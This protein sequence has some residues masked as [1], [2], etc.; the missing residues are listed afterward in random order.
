VWENRTIFY[1]SLAFWLSPHNG[2]GGQFVRPLLP[3]G[4]SLI[5]PTANKAPS[6]PS[7][8][9]QLAATTYRDDLPTL[10]RTVAAQT[11]QQCNLGD[12]LKLHR[13]ICGRIRTHREVRFSPWHANPHAES[14][15]TQLVRVPGREPL[16]TECWSSGTK[17]SRQ[18][19]RIR[20]SVLRTGAGYGRCGGQDIEPSRE[21]HLPGRKDCRMHI[22]IAYLIEQI[23]RAGHPGDALARHRGVNHGRFQALVP[24][25]QLH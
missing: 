4:K 3:S 13:G 24:Q 7:G 20:T 23:E 19:V 18:S 9:C 22:L 5:N 1:E 6:Q 14:V 12:V 16:R 8:E 11:V 21:G 17:I 2:R 15:R 25:Q 10:S